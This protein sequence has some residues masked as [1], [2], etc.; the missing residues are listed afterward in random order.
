M[1]SLTFITVRDRI[2]VGLKPWLLIAAPS[3]GLSGLL[4]N[5]IPRQNPDLHLP[6]KPLPPKSGR[7]KRYIP[8]NGMTDIQRTSNNSLLGGLR[9]L[10]SQLSARRRFQLVGLM[11][12]M[13]MGA[14]AELATIGAVLPFLALI[15]NPSLA[16]K[17]PLV[18]SI[19][20]ALGVR[21][22]ASVLLLATILF[23]VAAVIASVVRLTMSWLSYKLTFAIGADLANEVYRRTLYQPYKYHVARNTS[24][25][26]AGINKADGVAFTLNPIIQSIVSIV[27]S[28]AIVAA[29]VYID[30]LTALLAGSGLAV[31][32]WLITAISRRK[33]LTSGR[34]SAECEGSRVQV[35]QEGLGGIRDVLIDGTQKVYAAR[36]Y[37]TLAALSEARAAISFIGIVPRFLIEGIGMVLIALVAYSMSFRNGGIST[38]LPVLGALALGAQ[39]LLPQMQQAYFGWTSLT[40]TRQGLADVLEFLEQADPNHLSREAVSPLNMKAEI[41]M[42]KVSFRYG[43]T[44]PE[45]LRELDLIIPRGSKI[46]FIGETGSGKSTILD[47][48]MG[49]LEPTSGTIQ[50]DGEPIT[51]CN[52]RSWQASIAHVPQAVYLSDASIEENIAFGCDTNHVDRRLV[53][54]AA[55][56]AQLSDFISSLPAGYDTLVGERGVRLSGGQ[57]QRI[58]LARALYK[59]AAVL[60]LDEATSA[61][62]AGTEQAVMQAVDA[63]GESVTVLMVAHRVTSLRNCDRIVELRS[64]KI[65]RSGSY[66]E[67]I[68]HKSRTLVASPSL[69]IK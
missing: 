20:S 58:G 5:T 69:A 38:A 4:L 27:Y 12:L 15:A 33:L 3:R 11:L 44:Q 1:R 53:I 57:R 32:Y 31:F 52:R 68:E 42:R 48:I 24:E 23:A 13:F 43:E 30:Y 35:V 54:E 36:L 29:L 18:Q 49:L 28:I 63:L 64:G 10:L 22:D 50:V 61:L 17:Y 41:T 46:G 25:I 45:V 9:R 34:I 40:G 59:R 2:A 39:K 14:A 19:F 6:K 56:K 37:K 60:V 51:S 16:H 21:E 26:I 65:F 7:T 55:C 8:S 67:I 62:D 66:E 47:I